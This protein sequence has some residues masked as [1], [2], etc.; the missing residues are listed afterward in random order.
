MGGVS[1]FCKTKLS[2][3]AGLLDADTLYLFRSEWAGPPHVLVPAQ[4]EF[5]GHSG[6][7][8]EL[9]PNL[10]VWQLP[11]QGNRLSGNGPADDDINHAVERCLKRPLATDQ[12]PRFTG[13]ATSERR[14]LNQAS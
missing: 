14:D 1:K 9:H 5:L 4:S 2:G 6:R 7:A 13:S 12:L 10:T 8:A 11:T 3:T